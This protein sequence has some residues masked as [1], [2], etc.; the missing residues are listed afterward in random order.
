MM[1]N[2]SFIN[3]LN[4]ISNLFIIS[5]KFLWSNKLEIQFLKLSYVFIKFYYCKK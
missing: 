1:K 2:V 3:P 4:N 5:Y